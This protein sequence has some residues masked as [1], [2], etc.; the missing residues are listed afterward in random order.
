MHD[1]KDFLHKE[2]IQNQIIKSC[3]NCD[4]WYSAPPYKDKKLPINTCGKYNMHPPV[5]VI[6]FGCPD[7]KGLIPF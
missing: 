6:V 5:E 2:L 4:N 3:L 7:W 1:T